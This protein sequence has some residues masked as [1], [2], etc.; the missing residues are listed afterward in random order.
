MTDELGNNYY[1]SGWQPSIEFDEETGKGEITYVGTDPDYKNKYDSILEDWGFDPK[2]YTIEGTVR[3]SSWNTQLKGGETDTFFAFKG[4]VKRKNPALDEYF[5]ELCKIYLKKPKLK[6]TKFGGNTAFIWTMADWQLGKADYGVENTLKRYEEALIEGV[7]Q[8][9]ALRKG[10]T[11]IDEVF[12][13]GLGDLTENCDQSFYSSMPFNIELT[14]SQQ[15]KLARQLIMQTVDTFLPL[16]D[17]IT[18]CGIGGNHGEMTRSGKGQ[19]L[20]DRLD[21]SDM[22]HFEIVKEIMAQNPRYKKVNV[23]LPTDYHHLLE[24]KGKAVAITHGH[25]TTGG[26]GPE[27]KIMKWWQGQMF[28]WL[29][30]GAAEILITGHYHHPRML[31]Q[32][33]RTWFQCPSIDSSKDFTA[34]TGM[35]NDPGVL[36]FTIDKNGW[37]NYKIV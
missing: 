5:D 30:S 11:A 4:I 2:F 9:K 17:K 13:L 22:M 19:V 21:N 3:A 6:N 26:A 23:I 27:G 20:S 25:M 1:K 33:K 18:L 10:G 35:W 36:T 8:I 32:G 15:Y 31:K 34:R 37:S 29:P 12:L 7:N 16:V 24:I 28:G 14:L